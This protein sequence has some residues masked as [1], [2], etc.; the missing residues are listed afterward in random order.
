M[1]N[2]SSKFNGRIKENLAL[3]APFFLVFTVQ[4]YVDF[5]SENLALQHMVSKDFSVCS[6]PP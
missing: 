4:I 2:L 5:R 1:L 6:L 3:A